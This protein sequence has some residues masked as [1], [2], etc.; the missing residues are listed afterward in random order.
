[1]SNECKPPPGTPDGS[2]IPLRF[3]VSD[4]V[5]HGVWLAGRYHWPHPTIHGAVAEYSPDELTA[6][7]WTIAEPPSHE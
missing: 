4:L 7:G 2:V 1:M 3:G 6:A 5:V